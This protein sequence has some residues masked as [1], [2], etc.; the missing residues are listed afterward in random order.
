MI[1]PGMA[2]SFLD[3]WSVSGQSTDDVLHITRCGDGH[4]LDV[5]GEV[6]DLASWKAWVDG[7]SDLL[8]AVVWFL[9]QS[10]AWQ[11]RVRGARGSS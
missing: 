3:E 9:A 8:N 2:L 11:T 1:Q 5:R 4:D 7:A 6:P 10:L